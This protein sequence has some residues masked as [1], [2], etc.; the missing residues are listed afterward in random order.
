MVKIVLDFE[1]D[2]VSKSQ[3]MLLKRA[4]LNFILSQYKASQALQK[5]KM[6][7]NK[8]AGVWKF[9]FKLLFYTWEIVILI[10]LRCFSVS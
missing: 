9:N 8:I 3:Y 2:V 4:S 10:I 5:I 6:W 1:G 7:K